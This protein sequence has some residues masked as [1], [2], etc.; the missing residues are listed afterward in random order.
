MKKKTA[1]RD[2]KIRRKRRA[3][4]HISG[5]ATR[6]RVSVFRSIKDMFVQVI[7]DASGTT[8]VGMRYSKSGVKGGL[9]VE[10]AQK[11]GELIGKK[12]QEKNIDT[13]VFDRGGNKYHGR[14]RAIADG[15]RS[16]GVTM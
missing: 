11:F 9:G 3:R 12:C 13:V 2:L 16:A 14:V 15:I 4:A 7:D 5:T 8:L 10:T 1:Q 6:P